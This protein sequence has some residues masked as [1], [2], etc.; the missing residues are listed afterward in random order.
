METMPRLARHGWKD[1]Q[2]L[3]LY[4]QMFSLCWG[5]MAVHL[6]VVQE[7]SC[8]W[9]RLGEQ[10]WT[11][12]DEALLAPDVV[13]GGVLEKSK[14]SAVLG[15]GGESSGVPGSLCDCRLLGRVGKECEQVVAISNW[16]KMEAVSL[17]RKGFCSQP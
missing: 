12:T 9:E 17:G 13:P 7:E 15:T 14:A 6:M 11:A 16:T 1:S 10:E 4:S 8:W 2:S 5:V 3:E